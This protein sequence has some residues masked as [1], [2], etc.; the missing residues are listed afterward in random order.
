MQKW[1][2][3]ETE[4]ATRAAHKITLG[5][6]VFPLKRPLHD[7]SMERKAAADIG[8]DLNIRLIRCPL[9]LLCPHFSELL[10]IHRGICC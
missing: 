4:N 6:L 5:F 10:E 2:R 9:S 3:G 7:T 8:F 1:G